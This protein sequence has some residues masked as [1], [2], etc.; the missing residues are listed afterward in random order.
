MIRFDGTW[1]ISIEGHPWG[2]SPMRADALRTGV[3]RSMGSLPSNIPTARRRI[4][5]GLAILG[6]KIEIPGIGQGWA[7]SRAIAQVCGENRWSYRLLRPGEGGVNWIQ[8]LGAIVPTTAEIAAGGS[9]KATPH[10]GLKDFSPNI[11]R[12]GAIAIQ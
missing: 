7:F 3:R 4:T 11:L 1:A 9:W 5:V 8:M 6:G 10:V 12:M 2:S